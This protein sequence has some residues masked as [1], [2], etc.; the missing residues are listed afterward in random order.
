M[1]FKGAIYQFE[2]YHLILE[3]N[4]GYQ[5]KGIRLKILNA[6][7]ICKDASKILSLMKLPTY[8]LLYESFSNT[9]KKHI[10]F[11]K[12]DGIEIHS[13]TNL[14]YISKNLINYITRWTVSIEAVN[15]KITSFIN[16]I[17]SGKFYL[18]SLKFKLQ[19]LLIWCHISEGNH[20]QLD[21]NQSITRVILFY[22][23]VL[24]TWNS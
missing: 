5:S 10:I 19:H 17:F 18:Y 2:L 24:Y 3:E 9:L 13:L 20:L 15:G 11:R 7:W 1:Q 16:T 12:Y 6:F 22:S 8:I 23:R 4:Y 14:I 21:V